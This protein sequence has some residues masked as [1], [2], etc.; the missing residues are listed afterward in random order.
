MVT[1]AFL[2]NSR[3]NIDLERR[4][5][6]AFTAFRALLPSA[7]SNGRL[8]HFLF[9]FEARQTAI[10]VS[11]GLSHPS[12]EVQ[13]KKRVPICHYY[14]QRAVTPAWMGSIAL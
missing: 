3:S 4:P 9:F 5:Q 10:I 2:K 1:V 11:R 6:S 7:D 8:A 14:L 13:I 12:Q